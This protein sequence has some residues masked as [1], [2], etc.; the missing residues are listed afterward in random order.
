MARVNYA[1]CFEEALRKAFAAQSPQARNAYLDLASFYR[2]KLPNVA[3]PGI[4]GNAGRGAAAA[5]R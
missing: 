4:S 5:P 1:R 3:Q 2:R